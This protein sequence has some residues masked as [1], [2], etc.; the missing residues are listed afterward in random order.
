[1]HKKEEKQGKGEEEGG[2]KIRASFLPPPPSPPS[3]VSL[4]LFLSLTSLPV[5]L[6]RRKQK[7]EEI[8]GRVNLSLSLFVENVVSRVN[9]GRVILFSPRS[10]PLPGIGIAIVARLRATIRIRAFF[11]FFFFLPR[12]STL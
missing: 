7:G 10:T 12:S 8:A 5:F 1:M 11:S 4:C 9:L 3:F 6:P 2:E